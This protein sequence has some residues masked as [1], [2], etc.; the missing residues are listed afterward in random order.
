MKNK[1]FLIYFYI[2]FFHLFLYS[3]LYSLQ[4]LAEEKKIPKVF[5]LLDGNF[6]FCQIFLFTQVKREGNYYPART[7]KTKQNS[8]RKVFNFVSTVFLGSCNRILMKEVKTTRK[9][10]D[11]D[12]FQHQKYLLEIGSDLSRLFLNLWSSILSPFGQLFSFSLKRNRK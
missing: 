1:L 5:Q 6:L 11:P 4:D 8:V 9:R 7:K 10:Q 3:S 12:P 2:F